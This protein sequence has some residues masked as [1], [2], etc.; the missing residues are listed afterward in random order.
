MQ[1]HPAALRNRPYITHELQRLLAD[2]EGKLLE[3]ASGSG[4]HVEN[5][6]KALPSWTFQPTEPFDVSDLKLCFE[7]NPLPNVAEPVLLDARA[8]PAQWPGGGQGTFGCVLCIN[9][10][11]IAP[12]ECC[13]GLLAGAAKALRRPDGLLALYGPYAIDGNLSPESNVA[14]DESLRS[15]DDGWGIRDIVD[16]ME[17]AE[18]KGFELKEFRRMPANNFLVVF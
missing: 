1:H 5:L 18:A 10:I 15:R 6:A 4:A 16:V 9:M 17:A 7:L 13:L 14:F 8:P 3:L 2:K 11:H 12:Y